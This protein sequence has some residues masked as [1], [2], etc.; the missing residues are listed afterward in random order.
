MDLVLTEA[1]YQALPQERQNGEQQDDGSFRIALESDPWI[2]IDAATTE[3]DAIINERDTFKVERDEARDSI[4]DIESKRPGLK[5]SI[6]EYK[7][8]G[9]PDEFAAV[10]R[11]AAEIPT[12]DDP[13]VVEMQ[14]QLDN[15]KKEREEERAA[16]ER[17]E[18]ARIADHRR[19]RVREIVTK[20]GVHPE[21]IGMYVL[22]LE[23]RGVSEESNRLYLGPE[24][25][26][27]TVEDV[28]NEET[29]NARKI[30][31][32][33]TV[34]LPGEGGKPG[35]PMSLDPDDVTLSGDPAQRQAA[36]DKLAGDLYPNV[37]SRMT[38]QEPK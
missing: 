23:R 15:M 1:E 21:L 31:L 7:V 18:S 30:L 4:R 16:R 32:A 8:H 20:A 19:Q 17:A 33:K 22:D 10:K 3:R 35:T 9:T 14:T 36:L 27:K 38:G 29:G 6:E 28:I 11:R 34:T 26:R 12:P 5:R 24:G 2:Q 13:K 25:N 37:V